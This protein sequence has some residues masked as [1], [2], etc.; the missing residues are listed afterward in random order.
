MSR[1]LCALLML[2]SSVSLSAQSDKALLASGKR[3]Y[4]ERVEGKDIQR[5]MEQ[6]LTEWGRWKVAEAREDADLLVRL[7][8]AASKFK[9]D[10]LSASIASAPDHRV[11]WTS[12]KQKATG[13]AFHGFK[14]P[15]G[16][17]A[18]AIVEEM[19][20]AANNWLQ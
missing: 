11:L 6:A 15:F 9:G 1:L 14:S 13:N 20:A 17:A 2:V 12:T 7:Q 5:S 3:V 19:K 8:V 10:A 18:V 16:K 4:V